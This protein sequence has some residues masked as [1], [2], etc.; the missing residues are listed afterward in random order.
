MAVSNGSVLN[1]CHCC[2]YSV[3][4]GRNVVMLQTYTASFTPL[5]SSKVLKQKIKKLL[6]NGKIISRSGRTS[7]NIFSYFEGR[8]LCLRGSQTKWRCGAAIDDGTGLPMLV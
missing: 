7:Q 1:T 6:S 8:N 4:C 2:C 5:G 3:I